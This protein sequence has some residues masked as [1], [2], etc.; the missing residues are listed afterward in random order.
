MNSELPASPPGVVVDVARGA[1][2][3]RALIRTRFLAGTTA[4]FLEPAEFA[5]ESARERLPSVFF[6]AL[7]LGC[8]GTPLELVTLTD[9]EVDSE[10]LLPS[11]VVRVAEEPE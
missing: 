1:A 2:L 5:F 3:I 6:E 4:A 10:L 9:E 7:A 11:T 8:G